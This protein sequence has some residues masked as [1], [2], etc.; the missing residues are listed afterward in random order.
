MKNVVQSRTKQRAKNKTVKTLPPPDGN[1]CLVWKT[2][3]KS[4]TTNNVI[5]Y[6]A[7]I[8]KYSYLLQKKL[9]IKIFDIF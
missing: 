9:K 8:K 5:N 4:E 2:L 7:I 3:K 6:S 1:S